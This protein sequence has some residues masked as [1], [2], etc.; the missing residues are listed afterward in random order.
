MVR[1]HWAVVWGNP[2]GVSHAAL[3]RQRWAA[4]V[5]MASDTNGHWAHGCRWWWWW[6]WWWRYMVRCVFAKNGRICSFHWT[7]RSKKCFSFRGSSP[8]DL[9]TRGS[10]TGPRWGLCP[11]TPVVGSRSARSPCPPL[12]NPKYVTGC[13]YRKIFNTIKL[14]NPVSLSVEI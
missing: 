12:P 3:D 5:T 6:W 2:A 4:I 14:L 10:A 11:Q 1:W 8:P 9:P 7:F 13:F